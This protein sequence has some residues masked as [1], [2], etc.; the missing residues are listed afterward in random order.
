MGRQNKNA[1]M[2]KYGETKVLDNFTSIAVINH[3]IQKLR[4]SCSD[5]FPSI[6]WLSTFLNNFF[7]EATGLLSDIMWSL[8]KECFAAEFLAHSIR[9]MRSNK[10][11]SIVQSVVYL[12]ADP[13]VASMN[14][15]SAT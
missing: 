1:I 15:S 7:T 14:P 2:M 3:L 10:L 6:V 5:H 12:T 11:G 8:P 4:M 9:N 13:G